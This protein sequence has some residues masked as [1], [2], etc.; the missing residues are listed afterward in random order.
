[1][2]V[3]GGL[4]QGPERLVATDDL[5]R[6][7]DIGQPDGAMFGQPTPFGI[8]PDGRQAAFILNKADPVDNSYCRALVVIDLFGSPVPRAVDRGG[9][10][11]T[12]SIA[13]RGLLIDG[14]FPAALTPAWSPDGRWIAWLRRDGE[15]TRLWRARAD[16]GGSEVV[17]N[18]AT[19]ILDFAWS[20]D[21]ASLLFAT[22][23]DLET[24][25]QKIAGEGKEGWL[26]DDRFVPTYGMRPQLPGTVERKLFAISLADGRVRPA[27]ADDRQQFEARQRRLDSSLPSA[28]SGSGRRAWTERPK[29]RLF[30]PLILIAEAPDGRPVS[31]SDETCRG[32]FTGLWW[33]DDGSE[34]RFLR[35]EGWADGELG[36]YSWRPGQGAPVRRLRTRNILHGCTPAG[37]SLLCTSENSVTPRHIVRFDPATGRIEPVFDPNPEFAALRPGKVQ[38]L[39]WRNNRG[40]EAWGDLVLPP[41]HDGHSR[42]PLL[43]VQYT[44]LGFLRGGTGD[45]YPIHPLA[46]AGFA[47]LSL[48]QPDFVATLLPDIRTVEDVLRANNRDWAQRRSLL[49]SL[50]VGIDR[51]IATGLIDPTRI[52]LTGLSDGATTA[53]FAL[54]NSDRFAVAS[55][56]SCCLDPLTVAIN[57]G[58]AF[59]RQMRAAGFPAVNEHNSEFWKPFSLVPNARTM[60]RPILMQLADSEALIALESF[61]ALKEAGQPVELLVFPDERH[62]KWQPVHRRAIYERNIDWFRFWLQGYRDPDPAKGAQYRRWQSMTGASPVTDRESGAPFGTEQDHILNS[63]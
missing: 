13:I 50:E 52:G 29:D 46:A 30:G 37:R 49:S 59:A 14:G 20:R 57:T 51:A 42:L 24:V 36:F 60:S 55:I 5:L 8:S 18:Q 53:R 27:D 38:R 33:A 10:L 62:V 21:G 48:Q 17:T 22:Q 23:P 47:V 61:T 16:G 32:G 43:I 3:A 26:Y 12:S 7:R 4:R 11:I 1:M 44:S 58:P 19:D 54:L 39:F 56:S 35:R 34:L 15:V 41:D 45:E 40:L 28:V 25:R 31:C 63:D 6:L 2:P 9:S